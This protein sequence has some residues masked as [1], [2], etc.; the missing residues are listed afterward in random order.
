MSVETWTVISR[1]VDTDAEVL[2]VTIESG[3]QQLTIAVSIRRGEP[4]EHLRERIRERLRRAI[5]QKD[6]GRGRRARIAQALLLLT[7]ITVERP[8]APQAAVA[9]GV[10]AGEV[11]LGTAACLLIIREADGSERECYI[12]PNQHP[13]PSGRRALSVDLGGRI[14]VRLIPLGAEGIEGPAQDL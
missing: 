1:A 4:P 11:S 5:E 10:L 6:A 12:Q 2:Q 14:A 3:T 9:A 13:G 7:E 8:A